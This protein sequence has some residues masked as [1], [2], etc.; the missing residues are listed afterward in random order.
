MTQAALWL[1]GYTAIGFPMAC[2]SVRYAAHDTDAQR[3]WFFVVSWL[4][5]PL[6]LVVLLA[7][8][9]GIPG[10][11]FRPFEVLGRWHR[12]RFGDAP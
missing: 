12:Q 7:V 1:G 9:G 4:A 11:Q 6:S 10:V 8:Y 5:W 2:W 3:G